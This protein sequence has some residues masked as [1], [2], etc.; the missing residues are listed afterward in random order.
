MRHENLTDMMC[1]TV[2][3]HLPPEC[4]LRL[5]CYLT[6]AESWVFCE[7]CRNRPPLAALFLEFAENE[8][9]LKEC[10]PVSGVGLT[11][12]ARRLNDLVIVSDTYSL[13]YLRC[14]R[15]LASDY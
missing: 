11:T 1:C 6:D 13:Y 7:L 14:F 15:Q 8:V 10:A 12:V 3:V 9:A 2:A 5:G 4:Q